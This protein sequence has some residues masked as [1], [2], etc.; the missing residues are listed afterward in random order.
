[1]L[2]ER[3]Q[4]HAQVLEN[5]AAKEVHGSIQ[6]R[7]DLSPCSAGPGHDEQGFTRLKVKE[8]LKLGSESHPV[9]RVNP[10]HE[11]LS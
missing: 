2:P 6:S 7:R 3:I 8:Q 5:V 9:H 1:M 4:P 11:P 10:V